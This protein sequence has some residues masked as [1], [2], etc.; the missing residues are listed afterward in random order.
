MLEKAKILVVDDETIV[1][2]SLGHWF[3]DETGRQNDDRLCRRGR[4][5][6]PSITWR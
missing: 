5:H 6:T 2:E 4:A 1:H 3:R